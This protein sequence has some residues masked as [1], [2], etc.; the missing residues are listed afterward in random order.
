[1]EHRTDIGDARSVA[2][3]PYRPFFNLLNPV[4]ST[5]FS[6]GSEQVTTDSYTLN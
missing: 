1:M 5:P 4:F 3:S 6:K 2:L